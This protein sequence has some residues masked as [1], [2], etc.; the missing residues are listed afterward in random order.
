MHSSADCHSVRARPAPRVLVVVFLVAVGGAA[1]LVP[2]LG[3][4]QQKPLVQQADV[5]ERTRLLELQR[6]AVGQLQQAVREGAA[7][8][9]V[10]RALLEASHSLESLGA[11]PDSAAGPPVP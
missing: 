7:A 1:A 9:Q 4:A 3:A 5:K 8:D 6:A 10:R 11:E 2:A